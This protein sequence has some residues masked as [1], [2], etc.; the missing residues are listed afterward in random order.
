VEQIFKFL[1]F[2]YY[3]TRRRKISAE[4]APGEC[5]GIPAKLWSSSV[6]V[7][8]H[9]HCSVMKKVMGSTLILKC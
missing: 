1:Y 7:L 8:C 5:D 3:F 2:I 4:S 9:L 6:I